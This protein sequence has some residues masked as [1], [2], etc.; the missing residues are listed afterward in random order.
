MA[1][2]MSQAD[3]VA[4]HKAQLGDAASKFTAAADADFIRQVN[5]AA[6]ALGKYRAH[7][8]VGSVTLVADQSN[9]AAPADI[10]HVQRL[11]WGASERRTRQPWD[12][13]WP[14]SPPSVSVLEN[15][16]AKELWIEPAPTAAQIADLGSTFRFV[17][18]AGHVVD[19]TAAN[20][21][22]AIGDRGL[23]LLLSMIEAVKELMANGITKPIQWKSGIGS[24]PNSGT[25]AA[26]LTA[27][28][29][30][31]EGLV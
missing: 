23:L 7:M 27:L 17:Y 3:I 2:T 13:N 22:V 15:G 4:D 20:T 19:A 6:L 9:Y 5:K 28:R 1:G 24:V 10:R 29:I 31:L 8:V 26:V 16:G 21:T 12:N 14:G 18:F 25:P 30:E 11:I